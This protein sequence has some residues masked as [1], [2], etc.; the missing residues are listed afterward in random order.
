MNRIVEIPDD[1]PAEWPDHWS[2]STRMDCGAQGSFFTTL[3]VSGHPSAIHVS[4]F[5]RIV[6]RWGDVW[7]IIC[8]TLTETFGCKLTIRCPGAV[9]DL[10]LPHTLIDDGAAWSAAVRFY[11]MPG[12]WTVAFTG[13]EVK[14]ESS[15]YG[16]NG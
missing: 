10:N 13:W 8:R 9:L 4:N 3:N 14:H 1:L 2:G 6:G 15:G 11:K 12:A 16:Y 5:R 7:P